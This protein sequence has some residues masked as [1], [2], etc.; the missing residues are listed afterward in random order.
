MPLAQRVVL[1]LREHRLASR[2]THQNDP[3]FAHPTRGT[4]I[5]ATRLYERFMGA[6]ETANVARPG[7][8]F[9]SL[10]H[11]YATTLAG[12]GAPIVALQRWMGHADI[13]TTMIYAAWSDSHGEQS[14]AD[15]AFA[16]KNDGTTTASVENEDVA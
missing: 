13:S 14:W 8:T 3:V 4:H 7:I 11:T 15:R 5:E 1:A 10:R 16:T 2:Y 12:A 6:A 9:H